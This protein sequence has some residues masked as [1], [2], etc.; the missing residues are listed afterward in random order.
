MLL[1]R[2]VCKS[3]SRKIDSRPLTRHKK[4]RP[5][6]LTSATDSR[7]HTV[8]AR[9]ARKAPP[10]IPRR[11]WQLCPDARAR[12]HSV[13]VLL[14]KEADVEETDVLAARWT[15]NNAQHAAPG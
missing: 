9:K 11:R 7:A 6:D 3:P 5:H 4:Q 2:H 12:L 8:G 13:L 10:R 15:T 1:R 14:L